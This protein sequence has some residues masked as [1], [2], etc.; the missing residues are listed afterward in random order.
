VEKASLPCA[1]RNI[2]HGGQG[3]GAYVQTWRCWSIWWELTATFAVSE[4]QAEEEEQ[5]E[6]KI[7]NEGSIASLSATAIKLIATQNTRYGKRIRRTYTT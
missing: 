6:N 4:A 1:F 2:E 5:L 3:R 7:I